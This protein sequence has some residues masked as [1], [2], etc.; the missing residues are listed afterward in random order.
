MTLETSFSNESGLVGGSYGQSVPNDVGHELSRGRTIH[1]SEFLKKFRNDNRSN[2]LESTVVLRSSIIKQRRSALHLFSSRCARSSDSGGVSAEAPVH[3]QATVGIL[4]QPLTEEQKFPI[5]VIKE[6]PQRRLSRRLLRGKSAAEALNTIEEAK[7]IPKP[8]YVSCELAAAAKIFL[9]TYY[10]E[11][12]QKPNSRASRQECLETQLY[13]SPHLTPDQKN[14][15][16][17]T[18]YAQESWYL[19]EQRKLKSHHQARMNIRS[20]ASWQRYESIGVLGRGSFG[21]VRL[22]REKSTP[23]RSTPKQ[24]YAMKI[25]RKSEMLL[26]GQEGHLRAERDFLVASQGSD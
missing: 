18:F 3:S 11:L 20:N 14:S 19:R 15:I 24:V 22:V 7:T 17:Q 21:V 16:R 25:I 5:S 12:L 10:N 23:L 6:S 9:E 1:P 2:R 8:T 4:S 26:C 13:Y